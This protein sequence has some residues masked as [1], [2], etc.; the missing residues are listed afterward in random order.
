M[1]VGH[2]PKFSVSPGDDSN[3]TTVRVI[4]EL[5]RDLRRNYVPG[6]GR[7]SLPMSERNVELVRLAYATFNRRD[8]EGFL[9]LMHPDVEFAPFERALEG[10][11]AYHGHNGV[12]SWWNDSFTVLPDL[13]VEPDEVRDLEDWTLTRGRL[14]GHGAESGAVF[15][16]VVWHLARWEDGKQVWWSAFDT[17]ADAL[18]AARGPH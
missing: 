1:T 16:R 3:Q 8:L 11:G 14:R 18:E 12:R 2:Y 4:R 13:Q 10:G 9:A 6:V 17:E 15:E 5:H 7:Y